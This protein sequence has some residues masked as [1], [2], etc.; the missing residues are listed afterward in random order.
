M[1][2][3]ANTVS[4]PRATLLAV[5]FAMVLPTLLAWVYFVGLAGGQANRV[6]RLVY[7]LGKVVQ[8]G[9][10][11]AFVV[12]V[13]KYWPKPARPR[14]PGLGLGIGFGLLVALSMLA[15]YSL[16]LR[17]SPA[18]SQTPEMV[19]NKL[20]EFGV[21]SPM[22]F[23]LL[24]AFIALGHSLFEEYYYRWFIFGRLRRLIP[25]VPALIL[26]SLAF[27]AHHVIVL[28]VYLPGYFLTAV[29]PF[30]LAIA[31]GGA[32]WAWLY[33]RT[34]SLYPAW[35]SHAMVDAAI[36]IL[37]WDLMHRLPVGAASL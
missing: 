3:E 24:G 26:S 17:D 19:R 28:S 16:W 20:N 2:P 11:L 14:L 33:E 21:A 18:L 15:L 6:Q 25:W 29:V 22:A 27:M 34:G 37:G 9:F 36:F 31:L 7:V 10:P 12:L 5:G 4:R 30:S 1:G 23:I 32:V 8:F 35:V 13:E